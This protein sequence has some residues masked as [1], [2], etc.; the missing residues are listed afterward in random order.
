M[1]PRDRTRTLLALPLWALL[2]Y[3]TA[4]IPFAVFLARGWDVVAFLEPLAVVVAFNLPRTALFPLK[5]SER[6]WMCVLLVDGVPWML[7]LIRRE[8][9]GGLSRW[10]ARL[11]GNETDALSP[12]HCATDNEHAVPFARPLR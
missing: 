9:H 7:A 5:L 12:S 8:R 4:M 2:A 11:M 1:V 6:A 3:L 10:T